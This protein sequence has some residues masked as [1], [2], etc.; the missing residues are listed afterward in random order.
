[1]YPTIISGDIGTIGLTTDN[2]YHVI[3][4]QAGAEE[5]LLME[6][7]PDGMPIGAP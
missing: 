5:T 1:M 6:H 7:D 3:S 2:L 4:I